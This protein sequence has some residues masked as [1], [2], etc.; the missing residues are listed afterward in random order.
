VD[1]AEPQEFHFQ[2]AKSKVVAEVCFL[3]NISKG[4]IKKRIKM[5]DEVH[6]YNQKVNK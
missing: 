2:G 4:I 1:E 5:V 6:M 3:W